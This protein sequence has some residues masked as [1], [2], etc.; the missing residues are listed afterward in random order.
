M[1]GASE[2]SSWL[3]FDIFL[4]ESTRSLSGLILKNNLKDNFI[5]FPPELIN[6]M[7][8]GCLTCMDDPSPMIRSTVGT[9]ITTLVTSGSLAAW[10]ELLGKL[11]EYLDSSNTNLIEVITTEFGIHFNR[12]LL[13]LSRKYVKI[14]LLS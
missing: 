3:C 12:V 5:R 13:V 7:K 9:I 14:H 6:S 11:V 8:E 1:N 2:S 4:D 10:P